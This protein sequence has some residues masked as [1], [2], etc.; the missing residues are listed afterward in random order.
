MQSGRADWDM[1]SRTAE[2]HSQP[3]QLADFH[4]VAL[5]PVNSAHQSNSQHTHRRPI[6]KTSLH[7]PHCFRHLQVAYWHLGTLEIQVE[8]G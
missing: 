3:S 8:L 7:S 5:I 4:S 1:N 2:G 6:T